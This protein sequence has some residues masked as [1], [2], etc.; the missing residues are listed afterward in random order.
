M[1]KISV[2]TG[3]RADYGLLKHLCKLID[4]SPKLELRLIAT[5]SHLSS[6]HGNTI[7][8]I[9]N[10]GFEV[11]RSIDLKIE[12]DKADDINRAIAQGLEGFSAYLKTDRPDAVVV[13]GDRYELLS[14]G[15]ASL[16]HQIPIIHIHG[17]EVTEGAIDDSIRHSLTKLAHIHF[18]STEAYRKRIIQLGEN[19]DYVFNVGGLG[20]EAVSLL[21]LLDKESLQAD[22][23]YEF[24][25]KN[26][27]LTFHPETALELADQSRC[28]LENLLAALDEH[29]DIGVIV[30]LPNADA[31]HKDIIDALQR[32]V[33]KAPNKRRAYKSLGQLRYLSCLQFVD[34]V[35]G[36]SSSGILE[37]PSF[38]IATINIGDRQKGR[39]RAES[40]IDVAADITAIKMAIAQIY[41]EDFQTCLKSVVN[42]YYQSDTSNK[43]VALLEGLENYSYRKSFFDVNFPLL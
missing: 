36:N 19:P 5:G 18:T 14:I 39:I 33:A 12:G 20:A 32:F 27:L 24:G 28:Q 15:I 7:D 40:V 1:K 35:I 11:Y 31:G 10:D 9:L 30:T 29:P 43:I 25:S 37:A 3:T 34:A 8:E 22:L 23:N 21:K 17:G 16:I 2:V 41:D 4:L 42:P 38:N 13:L 6:L 26:M